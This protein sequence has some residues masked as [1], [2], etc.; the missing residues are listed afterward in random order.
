MTTLES[1]R[2]TPKKNIFKELEGVGRN[3]PLSIVGD[4]Y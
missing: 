3:S 4:D 2:D 1:K